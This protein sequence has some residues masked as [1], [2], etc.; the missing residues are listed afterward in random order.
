MQTATSAHVCTPGLAP[1]LGQIEDDE[2]MLGHSSDQPKGL[3][4]C[5]RWYGPDKEA[6]LRR[7]NAARTNM[8]PANWPG[9]RSITLPPLA[10]THD[11]TA[12]LHR[13]RA[14]SDYY[15]Y[16]TA[17]RRLA[18]SA[19]RHD[20]QHHQKWHCWL[21]IRDNTGAEWSR[22]FPAVTDDFGWLVEV[23]AC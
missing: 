16:E 10:R 7:R 13:S 8:P 23:P 6:W 12:E 21:Y 9:H 18:A 1:I 14:A 4:S 22:N 20:S 17:D 15:H 3:N 5:D 11:A 2:F 19:Y